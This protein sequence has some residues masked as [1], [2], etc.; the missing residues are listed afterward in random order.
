MIVCRSCPNVLTPTDLAHGVKRCK[1]CRVKL[2]GR[3]IVVKP[4]RLVL[5]K[6]IKVV[7]RPTP[8]LNGESWWVP[9]D[10]TALNVEA[11]KRFPGSAPQMALNHGNA[12]GNHA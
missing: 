6:K 12:F 9:L 11:L 1:P 8:T 3:V 2:P 4:R 5:P 10:R 7:A